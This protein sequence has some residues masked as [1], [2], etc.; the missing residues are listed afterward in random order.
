MS[1]LGHKRIMHHSN[2]P[3]GPIVEGTVMIASVV[4]YLCFIGKPESSAMNGENLNAECATHQQKPGRGK[5]RPGLIRAHTSLINSPNQTVIHPNCHQ[6]NVA[7]VGRE[8][9]RA[10][11][12][13][14]DRERL[15][16]QPYVVVSNLAVQLLAKAH[17]MPAPAVQPEVG[18]TFPM[19]TEPPAPAKLVRLKLF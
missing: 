1:A 14:R 5:P 6:L 12:G 11:A 19:E 8:R 7:I 15:V 18:V 2:R 3:D 17:S 16:A 4:C 10:Y 9:V 13:D